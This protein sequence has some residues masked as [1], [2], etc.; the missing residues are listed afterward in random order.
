MLPFA[1]PMFVVPRL[2]VHL[3]WLPRNLLGAGLTVT[4]VANFAMAWLSTAHA[5]YF[6]FAIAMTVAG[7]G[8]GVLNGDTAK[9]LQGALPAN[10]SGVASGIGATTR[11]VALLFG[12][13]ALGALLVGATISRFGLA[14]G[15]SGMS[16]AAAAGA[17]KRFSAG[18]VEGA[19][20][21]LPEGTRDGLGHLLRDAFQSG[22]NSAALAAAGVAVVC[23]TLTWLLM[24]GHA[25]AGATASTDAAFIPGE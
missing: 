14:A 5:S 7:I 25:V 3:R 1:L 20:V 8:A 21:L 12:V 24:N 19:M 10:R 4:A 13:A 17:A 6:L 23:L 16:A 11:F 18:D 2:S 9:A 15:H 22:F